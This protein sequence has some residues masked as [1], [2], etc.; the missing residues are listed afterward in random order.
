MIGGSEHRHTASSN[1][2]VY[3]AS[4]AFSSFTGLLTGDCGGTVNGLKRLNDTIDVLN[5]SS[6]SN[7]NPGK[8]AFSKST[9]SSHISVL[10]DTRDWLQRWNVHGA[11]AD[12]IAGF[13]LTIN[14]VLQLWQD[15]G[16]V[17]KHLFTRRLSQDCV[18]NFFGTIRMV[19]GQNDLPDPTKFRQAFRKCA[20][21]GFLTCG[22][23]GNCEPDADR[24]LA[25]VTSM[26]ARCIPQATAAVTFTSSLPAP[27]IL[28]IALDPV[29]ENVMAYIAGYLV[30]KG[31]ECHQCEQCESALVDSGRALHR[32]RDA[33]IGLKSYTG[34]GDNDAGSLKV[35]SEEFFHLVVV[36]FEVTQAQ[37]PSALLGCNV[38]TKL[39]TCIE[40]TTQRAVMVNRLCGDNCLDYMLRI[41]LRMQ[42][43][44]MC[45]TVSLHAMKGVNRQNRKFL[46]V[47]SR[48]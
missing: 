11:P 15:V 6:I 5:S 21:N 23:S 47:C 17:V 33:L 10:Q 2:F 30:K 29:D 45:E 38:L 18:E 14:A 1:K 31:Q 12:S 28:E 48:V 8:R 36:A 3:L 44:K 25:I 26:A 35:P 42:L 16:D 46:K 41:F 20:L 32:D 39:I 13:Q 7:P 37:A 43:H 4:D 40:S 9:E 19:N 24:L 34:C 27:P 22:D